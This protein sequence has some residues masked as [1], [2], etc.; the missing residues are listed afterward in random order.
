[1][2]KRINFQHHLKAKPQE[3][4][5]FRDLS[6]GSFS[7]QGKKSKVPRRCTLADPCCLLLDQ[8]S[9]I[10]ML[11]EPQMQALYII[12][13]TLVV[14]LKSKK[15]S[16]EKKLILYFIE[17]IIPKILLFQYVIINIKYLLPFS[18]KSSKSRAHFTSTVH[19]NQCTVATKWLL[20][21]RA[22]A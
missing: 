4:P 15:D 8:Q 17:P 1:M 7:S 20:C 10:E 2:E 5:N 22:Q 3:T 18:I 12:V 21:L 9:P 14:P 11:G 13:K 6:C 16:S 19:L